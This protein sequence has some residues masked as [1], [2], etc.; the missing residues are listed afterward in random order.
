MFII[1]W[2]RFRLG[3]P[4]YLHAAV[5]SSGGGCNTCMWKGLRVGE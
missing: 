3:C 2:G 4:I 1:G 5:G